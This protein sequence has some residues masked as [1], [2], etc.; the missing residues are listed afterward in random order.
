MLTP[1]FAGGLL[2]VRLFK[3]V[4][5]QRRS[6]A[7]FNR[8][9][10]DTMG[11]LIKATCCCGFETE[12]TGGSGRHTYD[13]KCAAP[14]LCR[15]CHTFHVANYL[16][17]APVCSACGTT[18]TFYNASQLQERSSAGVNP[19]TG[20]EDE[21]PPFVLPSGGCLCPHCKKTTMTFEHVGCWG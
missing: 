20:T 1:R 5:M 12:F 17:P 8:L 7:F 11:A 21:K 14:A 2:L 13:T 10:T 3:N 15:Q 16:A 18:L 4:Q 6:W 9:Y 19:E